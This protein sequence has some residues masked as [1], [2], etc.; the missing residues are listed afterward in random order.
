MPDSPSE[1]AQ[2]PSSP[3]TSVQLPPQTSPFDRN[4]EP[5]QAPKIDRIRYAGAPYDRVLELRK[6][7][8][9]RGDGSREVLKTRLASM[10]AAGQKR[11]APE[12]EAMDPSGTVSG[13]RERAPAQGATGSDISNQ[14]Q[15]N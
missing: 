8:G 3:P 14:T 13:E 1:S 5:P 6:G 9:Y 11:T 2:V 12:G 4:C 10:D 15:E 7:R